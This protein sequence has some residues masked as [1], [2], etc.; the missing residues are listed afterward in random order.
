[1]FRIIF[2]I[3]VIAGLSLGLSQLADMEGKLI[4]QWPGGEIQP[5]LMQAV[6]GLVLLLFVLV[7]GWS[8][9]RFILSSPDLMSRYFKRKKQEKGLDALSSG[10]IALG[11]GDNNTALR[12]AMQARRSLP[13][14]P[15]TQMLR[16]QAAELQGDTAQAT[17]IY[18]SMLAAADTEVMG[19]RGL[20]MLALQQNEPVAAEQYADRATVRR[21]DLSWAVMGLFDLQCRRK[22]WADALETLKIASDHGHVSSRRGKRDRAVLLTA[23]AMELEDDDMETA[24][25]YAVEANRLAPNLIPAA[26]VAGRIYASQGKMGP[27]LKIVRKSWR[28]GPHPDLAVVS[29]YARPGDSVRDRMQRIKDLAG[30]TPG[31]REAAIALANAAVEAGD[32][33]MARQALGPLAR[34][35]PT[36]RV[37]TLMARIEAADS[38]NKGFIKEWLARGINAAGDPKW[39]ADGVVSDEWQPISPLTGKL[40]AFTWEVPSEDEQLSYDTLTLKNLLTGLVVA[41]GLESDADGDVVDGKT[42]DSAETDGQPED[43]GDDEG[44]ANPVDEAESKSEKKASPNVA[45]DQAPE[46]QDAK[47]AAP[48]EDNEPVLLGKDDKLDADYEAS[49]PVIVDVEK[50]EIIEDDVKERQTAA[51][52]EDDKVVDAEIVSENKQ[53]QKKNN[54][55]RSRKRRTKIYVAPPAPDDPGTDSADDYDV[56]DK[57]RP[58]R[59]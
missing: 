58:I 38:G 47:E 50:A 34:A 15:M 41:E 35:R 14:E 10:L 57:M 1:M 28:L 17:R 56:P 43:G 8:I 11:A 22:G 7:L 19:L 40:D 46:G 30:L 31:H 52:T 3:L 51:N 59:Y 53:S 37:C 23:L 55:R 9:F 42:I 48:D 33:A 54:K 45:D 39:V 2:L 27:A 16:A 36:Q 44:I 12:H 13:N 20:Y 26:V 49:L 6:I 18:E 29:A 21:P 25:G 5:T 4:I 32:W 24:L